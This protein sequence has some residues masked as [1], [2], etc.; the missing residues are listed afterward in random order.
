MKMFI[1][2]RSV[3]TSE[4]YTQLVKFNDATKNRQSCNIRYAEFANSA[5]NSGSFSRRATKCTKY[6]NVYFQNKLIGRNY[7][8]IFE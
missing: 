7:C 3:M 5:K 1:F 2:D 4:Q 6:Q 8:G